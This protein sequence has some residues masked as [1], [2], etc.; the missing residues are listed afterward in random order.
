MWFQVHH[1]NLWNGKLIIHNQI[2]FKINIFVL[3][4]FLHKYFAE[5]CE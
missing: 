5:D 3:I 2:L 4:I 1:W